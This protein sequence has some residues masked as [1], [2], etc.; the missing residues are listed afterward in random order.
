MFPQPDHISLVPEAIYKKLSR[1]NAR[2]DS[3]VT[4]CD[5][6]AR[7]SSVLAYVNADQSALAVPITKTHRTIGT[8]FLTENAY[9]PEA[10]LDATLRYV[11]EDPSG[12]S[13]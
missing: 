2:N 8:L 1:V 11:E 7:G 12:A 10:L 13:N 9:R 3:Q 5:E 4:V 6:M